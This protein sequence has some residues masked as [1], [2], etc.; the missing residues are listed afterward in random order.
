MAIGGAAD[1]ILASIPMEGG[2]GEEPSPEEDALGLENAMADLSNALMKN[3]PRAAADAFR[4]AF[5]ELMLDM[6]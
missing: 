5:E 3:E 6:G 1:E 4:R 2:A